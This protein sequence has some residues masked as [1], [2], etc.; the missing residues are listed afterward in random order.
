MPIITKRILVVGGHGKVSL[1]MIPHLI[2][3]GWHVTSM[4][5]SPEQK[6]DILA[7]AGDSST[8]LEKLSILVANL[9]DVKNAGDAKKI[10]DQENI[11]TVLWSAG[12]S[13]FLSLFTWIVLTSEINN[14][15]GAGGKGGV[16]ETYAID[17]DAAK[18]FISA[19]ISTTTIHTFLMVSA[20]TMR[21]NKAPWWTDEDWE[22]VQRVNTLVLP[23]YYMA[24][25]AADEFLTVL[26][27]K[28]VKTE[29]PESFRYLI[30]RPGF[31]GN[32]PPSGKISFG[33]TGSIGTVSRADVAVVAA[34]LLA[35]SLRSGW[36]D[37]RSGNETV[38]NAVKRVIEDGI[39]SMDG[40]S[41]EVM[42]ADTQL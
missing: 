13:P 7:A 22:A 33:K 41:L 4:I 11:D 31:Y 42:A 40:E 35:N 2:A 20:L 18:H 39:N 34:E 38:K 19:S 37:M 23:D 29:G 10:L 36:F 25:L 26:G 24:K 8:T 5:R 28:R 1:F 30:L 21:R 17:R 3:R 14:A 15:L 27:E 16:E 12:E 6:S 9:K 32:E